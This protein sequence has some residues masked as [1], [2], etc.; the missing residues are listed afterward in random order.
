[1]CEKD[2]FLPGA[3]A[4]ADLESLSHTDHI[5]EGEKRS[6]LGMFQ[7]WI[8]FEN[9]WGRKRSRSTAAW[10]RATKSNFSSYLITVSQMCIFR[11]STTWRWN[12][13]KLLWNWKSKSDE[14]PYDCEEYLNP[15]QYFRRQD[16]LFNLMSTQS[17]LKTIIHDWW[18]TLLLDSSRSISALKVFHLSNPLH[19]SITSAK[20]DNLPY[21]FQFFKKLSFLLPS[22]SHVT[23]TLVQ[24]FCFRG[25]TWPTTSS[26][27]PRA[28]FLNRFQVRATWQVDLP[29]PHPDPKSKVLHVATTTTPIKTKF[30]FARRVFCCAHERRHCCKQERVLKRLLFSRVAGW[31]GSKWQ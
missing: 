3:A 22:P 10:F 31:G 2:Y 25:A 19:A 29:P 18:L 13:R 7:L 9:V 14:L 5:M 26:V 17:T 12:F 1:M 30:C 28:H 21:R 11:E 24:V 6:F 4:S 23:Q 15:L 27:S 16:L 8:P 20:H